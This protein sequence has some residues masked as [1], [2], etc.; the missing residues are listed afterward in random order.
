MDATPHVERANRSVRMMT[1]PVVAIVDE[2]LP[3]AAE[4]EQSLRVLAQ[5]VRALREELRQDAEP[6]RT[7]ELLVAAVLA[8]NAA[9]R[10]GLGF[11]GTS[12]VAQVRSAAI[13][14]LGATGLAPNEAEAVVRSASGAA[15][16]G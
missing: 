4:L 2:S 8:A 7:R 16:A 10:R 6:A 12:L 15:T 5:A 14:L 1:R 3:V 9:Y 11:S 13:N